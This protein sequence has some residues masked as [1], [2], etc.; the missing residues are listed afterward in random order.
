MNK[1]AAEQRG[2]G[3]KAKSSSEGVMRMIM[4]MTPACVS[5]NEVNFRGRSCKELML[6]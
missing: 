4:G 3:S 5:L 6:F 2:L 1:K